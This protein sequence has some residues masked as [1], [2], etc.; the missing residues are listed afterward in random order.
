[1]ADLEKSFRV[2]TFR[3]K[4]TSVRFSFEESQIA[5]EFYG[6]SG[7]TCIRKCRT[8]DSQMGRSVALTEWKE[9]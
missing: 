9:V 8:A 6:K 4:W 2:E 3:L 7:M 5:T 1:M